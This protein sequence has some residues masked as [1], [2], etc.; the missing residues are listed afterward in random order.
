MKAFVGLLNSSM[1]A[2]YIAAIAIFSIQNIKP[3]S[4]KF[5]TLQSINLP[6]GV[7]LTF[8]GAVGIIIGWFIPL[9]FSQRRR[10]NTNSR[11]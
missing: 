7:L 5:L 4:L 10:V 8:C 11:I 9:L 1:W 2:G 6:V 3:V